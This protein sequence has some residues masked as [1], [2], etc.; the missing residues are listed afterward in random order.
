MAP[1]AEREA[2][3]PSSDER[4]PEAEAQEEEEEEEEMENR[5]IKGGWIDRRG[6]VLLGTP[7]LQDVRATIVLGFV[8]AL[9]L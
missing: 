6:T 2:P 5:G 1:L 7:P 8:R 3:P 4:A 9:W